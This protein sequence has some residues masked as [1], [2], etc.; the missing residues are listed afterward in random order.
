M[1]T[2]NHQLEDISAIIPRAQFIIPLQRVLQGHLLWR[3]TV[4]KALKVTKTFTKYILAA[5]IN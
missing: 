5:A 4:Y 3:K 1:V 2:V